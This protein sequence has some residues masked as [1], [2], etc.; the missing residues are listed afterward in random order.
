MG[1]TISTTNPADF[2]NRVQTLFNPKL[3]DA[4]KYNLVIAD[5]GQQGKFNAISTTIRFF[6]PRPANTSGVGAITEGTTPANLTEVGVGYI[7]VPLSQRGALAKVTDIVLAT[8][9]L[10][11]VALYTKTMGAD[12]ALD[13]DTVCRNALVTGLNDS[14]STYNSPIQFYFERFAGVTNTGTSSTD[15]STLAGLSK[16]N[17]KHTRATHLGCITTLKAAKVPMINGKFVA[18]VP[19]QIMHD[20]R[21]DTTWVS[22]AVFDVG[23]LWKNGQMMLDGAVFVEAT[24]PFSEYNTYKTLSTSDAGNGLIFS[25]IYLGE[26]AFGVPQLANDRA[27]SS[28]MG[29]KLIILA[30]PDKQDPLNLLTTIG[31]KTLYGAKAFITN[32]T[33]EVPRYVLLRTKSTF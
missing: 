28:P 30:Q 13:L 16:S 3:L 15:F 27:G 33:A 9:L 21:Q 29:P 1:A 2:A 6:R 5:Y 23:A 25:T 18:V 26:S 4:L 24:N 32:V 22:G 11:T 8:D 14:N 31:W 20:M 7:D 12:A 19:P 17:G 10:N